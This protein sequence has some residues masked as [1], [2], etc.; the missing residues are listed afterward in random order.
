MAFVPL[1]WLVYLGFGCWYGIVW[2][3]ALGCDPLPPIPSLACLSLV[4]WLSAMPLL[5]LTHDMPTVNCLL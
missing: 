3:A 2:V 4:G 5:F 1:G